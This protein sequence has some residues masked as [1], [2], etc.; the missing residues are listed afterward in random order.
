MKIPEGYIGLATRCFRGKSWDVPAN[1]D[2][3][4]CIGTYLQ[5][6]ERDPQEEE[7]CYNILQLPDDI[8]LVILSHLSIRDVAR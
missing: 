3:V 4:S 1:T 2:Q 8:W 5:K 7:A 6:T